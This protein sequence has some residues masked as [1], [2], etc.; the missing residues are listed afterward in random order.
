VLLTEV[1]AL[2]VAE[3]VTLQQRLDAIAAQYGRHVMAE[4][5]L[6]MEPWDATRVVDGLRAEPPTALDG[7]AV[8]SVEWFEE[9]GLLR[10]QLGASLRVQIR[11]SGTEPKVKLYAEGIDTD[12]HPALDALTALLA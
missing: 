3:G 11:P 1:A 2:G 4:R 5:S 6:R 10:L 12:P 7:V 9:A 8:T